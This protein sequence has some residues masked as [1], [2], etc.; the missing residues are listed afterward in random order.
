MTGNTKS[1]DTIK[2]I[3][4][5]NII[6]L[7]DFSCDSRF[8]EQF[9]LFNDPGHLNNKGSIIFSNLLALEINSIL[10]LP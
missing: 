5:E 3:I 7:I 6:A 8:I 2:S 4:F 10:C 1:F 9:H